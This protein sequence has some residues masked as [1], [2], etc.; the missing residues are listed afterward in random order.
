MDIY[1]KHNMVTP[2]KVNLSPILL[3][4]LLMFMIMET[5]TSIANIMTTTNYHQ[6]T[7]AKGK[8]EIPI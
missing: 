7:V 2:K 8:K 5:E 3:I 1:R 6:R 4:Q